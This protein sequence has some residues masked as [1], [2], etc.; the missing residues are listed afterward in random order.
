MMVRMSRRARVPVILVNPVSNLK[1]CPPFKS[2]HGSDL[3]D[4]QIQRVI[5]LRKQAG[6][7]LMSQQTELLMQMGLL[8]CLEMV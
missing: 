4:A 6:A 1:D 3:S 5:E 7:L 2:E 8:L